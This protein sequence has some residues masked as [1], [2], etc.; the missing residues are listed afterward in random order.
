MQTDHTRVRQC[1]PY[2]NMKQRHTR[3]DSEACGGSSSSS[4]LLEIFRISS[5]S[6]VSPEGEKNIYYIPSRL[7]E[8]A[9][10]F[11]RKYSNIPGMSRCSQTQGMQAIS[12]RSSFWGAGY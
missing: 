11:I 10:S 3:R 4:F 8:G 9:P 1:S 5:L 12:R 7:G 6:I 2:I